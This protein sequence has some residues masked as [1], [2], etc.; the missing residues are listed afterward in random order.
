MSVHCRVTCF[1]V[2]ELNKTYNSEKGSFL[3]VLLEGDKFWDCIRRAS[4][5]ATAYYRIIRINYSYYWLH[6]RILVCIL[7]VLLVLE[8]DL[9][10]TCTC[11]N[12]LHSVESHKPGSAPIVR[13]SIRINFIIFTP[14]SHLFVSRTFNKF[15]VSL[16]N[17]KRIQTFKSV[18]NNERIFI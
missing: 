3:E 2:K 18:V 12:I 10:C 5:K 1:G 4:Y 11:N 17:Y 13:I 7:S 6:S 8:L 16:C 14:A 15:K 9:H